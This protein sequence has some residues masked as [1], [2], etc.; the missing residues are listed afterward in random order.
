M[1]LLREHFYGRPSLDVEREFGL[2]AIRARLA[3][4][5]DAEDAA[6]SADGPA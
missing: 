2:E 5:A 4:A 6:G 3:R 1:P